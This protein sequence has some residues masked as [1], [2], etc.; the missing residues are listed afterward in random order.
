MLSLEEGKIAA[1]AIKAIIN[2]L[3][4]SLHIETSK[5]NSS[6]VTIAYLN[7]FKSIEV[8]LTIAKHE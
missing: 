2:Q 1:V 5:N 7:L 3:P 4:S 6:K 8:K